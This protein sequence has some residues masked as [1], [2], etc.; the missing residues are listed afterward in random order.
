MVK[1]KRRRRIAADCTSADM[2]AIERHTRAIMNRDGWRK[3]LAALLWVAFS[4]FPLRGRVLL[5]NYL[6]DGTVG[7]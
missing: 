7:W 3:G 1:K 4:V 5:A 2:V 6:S